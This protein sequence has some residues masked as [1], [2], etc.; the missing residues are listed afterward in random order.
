MF[1]DLIKL[2]RKPTQGEKENRPSKKRFAHF[3]CIVNCLVMDLRTPS[4]V[5]GGLN[6]SSTN[7]PLEYLL[8]VAKH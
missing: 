6:R 7:I 1:I 8:D 3:N 2:D 5:T 4:N